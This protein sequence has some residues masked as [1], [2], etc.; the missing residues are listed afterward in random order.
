MSTYVPT[1]ESV[2]G[3]YVKFATCMLSKLLFSG[4]FI[5]RCDPFKC[6]YLCQKEF[7]SVPYTVYHL[8]NT[9]AVV[10]KLV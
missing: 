6:H 4:V 2:K 10:G 1:M 8:Y 9:F 5:L 3:A 7:Y